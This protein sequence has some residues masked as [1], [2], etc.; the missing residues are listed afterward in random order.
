VNE[1]VDL[2]A[3][4]K[5]K[6]LPWIAQK[7]ARGF[8]SGL[9]SSVS[10]G[11]GVEFSQ[12]RAYEPGDAL[13]NIDWKLFARSDRY[14]VRE[15][16]QE[17]DL[18]LW[19]LIDSSASMSMVS[20][21][22]KSIDVNGLRSKPLSKLDF[23]KVFLSSLSCIAQEQ[24]D[25]IGLV[26]LE[27]S[28]TSANDLF[29]PAKK[30]H[31]HWQNLLLSLH[32]IKADGGFPNLENL[33]P[34]FESMRHHGVL[35]VVSDFCQHN[36]EIF[37]LLAQFN[38]QKTDVICVQLMCEDELNFNYQG[39]IKFEEPETGRSFLLSANEAKTG[40][41]QALNKHQAQLE[42]H[43][44]HLGMQHLLVN[45][46][47]PIHQAMHDLFNLQTTMRLTHQHSH[48]Q[49]NANKK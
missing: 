25:A 22:N 23:A 42:A 28:S 17:S 34:S 3:L 13:A 37:E 5:V 19:M 36:Q 45:V 47:L 4:A 29:I 6:G 20:K 8:L 39:Q 32:N 12:Y 30:G 35:V 7:V 15:A 27:S 9:H 31:A 1:L 26:S 41:L 46:D 40:F 44:S 21:Q 2:A 43:I 33:L 14:F 48:Q 11:S 10:R 38:T 24:G 18:D 49:R 16:Y